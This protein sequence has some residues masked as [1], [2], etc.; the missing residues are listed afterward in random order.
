MRKFIIKLLLFTTSSMVLLALVLTYAEYSLNNYPSVFQL[1]TKHFKE[2]KKSINT[3]VLGSSHNNTAI[4]PEFIKSFKSANLAYGGQNIKIDSA[5]L[6]TVIN[7]LPK[8]KFVILELSYQTLEQKFDPNYYRNSLYLRAYDI[9]LFGRP[10]NLK[11]YSIYLSNPTF[12]KRFLNPF[13]SAIPINKFGYESQVPSFENRFKDLSYNES[14]L[15]KDTSNIFIRRHRYEDINTYVANS[16]TLTSMIELCLH[17]EIVPII[18]SPPVY[19]SYLK[20]YL[21]QKQKRRTDYIQ[22]LLKTY[23]KI[24][25]LNYEKHPDFDVYDFKNEDHLNPEGSKKFS[26]LLNKK[27][28]EIEE[29][30]NN[31]HNIK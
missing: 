17:K 24:V 4:N 13:K 14:V 30:L 31:I 12:Y 22:N 2:N 27:L 19:K 6:N 21:Q 7:G 23:S 18:I 1:K 8:L 16:N 25:Y 20:S 11:D 10:I 29:N 26:I 9:N 5:I 15:L 28:L 3:L